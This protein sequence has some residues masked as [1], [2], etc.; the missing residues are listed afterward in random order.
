[1]DDARQEFCGRAA[2]HEMVIGA[3]EAP[4]WHRHADHGDAT[5]P[6]A[7][8]RVEPRLHP[9]PSPSWFSQTLVLPARSRET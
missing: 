3:G 8:A 6:D 5:W 1:M 7:A 4:A 9:P 2:V